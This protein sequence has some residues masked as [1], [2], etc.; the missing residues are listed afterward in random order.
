MKLSLAL[1]AVATASSAS[2]FVPSASAS[3]KTALYATVE[4]TKLIPPKKVED[5]A[6]TASDLY[7]QNVQ[8]TYG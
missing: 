2:A 6:L 5:L 7:A 8:T 4:G 3:P 1:L